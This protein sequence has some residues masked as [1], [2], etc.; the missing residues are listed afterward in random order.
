MVE[1]SSSSSCGKDTSDG[2]ICSLLQ[3][4]PARLHVG[5]VSFPPWSACLPQET[6]SQ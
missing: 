4:S 6:E 3:D 1:A 2:M 5:V